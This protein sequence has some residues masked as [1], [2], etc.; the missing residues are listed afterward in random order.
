MWKIV[1]SPLFWIPLALVVAIGVKTSAFYYFSEQLPPTSTAT[2]GDWLFGDAAPQK[3]PMETSGFDFKN[4]WSQPIPLQGEAP[5]DFS[6][7]EKS[8]FPEDCGEC[9]KDQF[10]DW[11][12]S[13]HSKSVGPGLLGQLNPPWL[14]RESIE[15][16]LDC[17]APLGEQRIFAKDGSGGL[18]LNEDRVDGL[19]HKGLTCA[20]CHVRQHVRYGPT[21]KEPQDADLPHNGFTEV[22]NFG[23]SEFCRPC[24][25]FEDFHRRVAGKLVEDT[26]EQWKASDYAKKGVQCADCH[27]PDR[28]HLWKGIHDPEMV[29]SGVDIKAT[30]NGSIVNVSVTSK[31]VGH[32][33]PTYVTPQ[34]IVRATHSFEGQSKIIGQEWIGWYVELNLSAERFD[35]RIKPGETANFKFEFPDAIGKYKI[36][37]MVFPDEFYN[38]FFNSLLGNVPGGVDVKLLKEAIAETEKSSYTLFEKSWNASDKRS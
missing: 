23:D 19:L 17:H 3:K 14:D 29:K 28:R 18:K 9:H 27:M 25:Q 30:K 22:K 24:H 7:E 4:H 15:M 12:Q 32:L 16:C 13:R 2:E 8:L 21:P 37:V 36:E 34:V 33:F 6:D 31:N 38:R 10:N 11:S 20:G 26:Y 35:T 5:S 1:K